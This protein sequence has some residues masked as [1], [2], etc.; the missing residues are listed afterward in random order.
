MR[1]AAARA[2][3]KGLF[4]TTALAAAIGLAV[5]AAANAARPLNTDD[6]RIVDA[7]ACQL[8]SWVRSNRD[9]TEFW[10]LPGCNVTG[11]LELSIGGARTRAAG[12]LA[13]T[14]VIVQGKTL[15]RQLRP[16]DW[17]LGMVAGSNRHPDET[18][19]RD[20][21]LYLPLSVSMRDDRW[22]VHTNLGVIHDQV[23]HGQRGTWGVGTE[24]KLLERTFFVGEVFG[25]G[26]QRPLF[27]LGLRFWA[28]PDRL[29]IDS[30]IGNRVG[31]DTSER[32][33]S[34]GLRWL[35]P[36]FLP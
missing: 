24:V 33:L 8:E 28:I 12:E 1:Q 25:E 7:K 13:T 3:H 22:V 9:S 19:R 10:A 4:A 2:S 29:Q 11:N 35:P 36:A 15:F 5:P 6:A 14:N 21:Y 18:G 34:I 16:N 20:W 32:F 31:T 17:G 27:Q 30:T 26:T 23:T